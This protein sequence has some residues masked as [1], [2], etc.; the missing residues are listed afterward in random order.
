MYP[1]IKLSLKFLLFYPDPEG[2][3]M[4]FKLDS[5]QK[6]DTP[7]SDSFYGM[8]LTIVILLLSFYCLEEN[9]YM[10]LCF[11]I[12]LKAGLAARRQLYPIQDILLK[13]P[14]Q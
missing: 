9:V 13:I 4:N 10:L 14:F 6:W 2:D 3:K 7:Y 5:L 11:P 8:R 1:K 12:L